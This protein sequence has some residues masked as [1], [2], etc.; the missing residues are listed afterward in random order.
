MD[1]IS[2]L[3]SE[4]CGFTEPSNLHFFLRL[5]VPPPPLPQ[6]F[7]SHL[8]FTLGNVHVFVLFSTGIL[9]FSLLIYPTHI[10]HLLYIC[11]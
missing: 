9:V 7:P 10:P 8:W 11:T 1:V 5:Q 2:D 6:L 3:V 4:L